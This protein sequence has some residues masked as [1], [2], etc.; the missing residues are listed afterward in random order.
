MRP[1]SIRDSLVSAA[2]AVLKS[3]AER[4]APPALTW[5]EARGE[6]DTDQ[7]KVAE[8]AHVGGRWMITRHDNTE[9]WDWLLL[10]NDGQVCDM[11]WGDSVEE[12]K[13]KI[14]AAR[15]EIL[16]IVWPAPRAKTEQAA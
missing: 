13:Q 10:A 3:Y 16:G 1:S 11:G 8:D 4:K 7:P 9:S 6:L 12:C 5:K 2:Q 14:A 15:A